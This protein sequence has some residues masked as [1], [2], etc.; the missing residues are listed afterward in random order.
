MQTS[1][2]KDLSSLQ[3]DREYYKD[4][5]KSKRLLTQKWELKVQSRSFRGLEELILKVL[6]I[7][8]YYGLNPASDYRKELEQKKGAVSFVRQS[9][10]KARW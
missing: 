5:V 9:T 10:K 7:L 8:A 2:Q 4:L 6:D 3:D 1:I